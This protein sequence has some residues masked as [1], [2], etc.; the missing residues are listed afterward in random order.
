MWGAVIGAAIFVIAQNYLREIMG[1]A[2]T[3]VGEVPVL[4]AILDPDR[5]LLWLGLLFIVSVYSFP[6]GIVGRFRGTRS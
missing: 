2:S 5:W 3:A 6:T 4:T 1:G